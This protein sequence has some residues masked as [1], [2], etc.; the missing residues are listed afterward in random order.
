M[1]RLR[2]VAQAVPV[3]L[4][5]RARARYIITN[6]YGYH[7]LGEVYVSESSHYELNL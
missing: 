1:R 5:F 6:S 3:K 4:P 7:N 2:S